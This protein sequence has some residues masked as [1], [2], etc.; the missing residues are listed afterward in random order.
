MITTVLFFT[1]E[2]KEAL[3]GHYF[4]VFSCIWQNS[5]LFSIIAKNWSQIREVG[6]R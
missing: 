1:L 6:I 5:L 3:V 4:R 2:K